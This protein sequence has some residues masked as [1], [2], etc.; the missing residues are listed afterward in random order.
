M[1][2]SEQMLS[3][4]LF[5]GSARY[6]SNRRTLTEE[7]KKILKEERITKRLF[8]PESSLL[9]DYEQLGTCHETSLQHFTRAMSEVDATLE[10][11]VA[12]REELRA[13]SFDKWYAH[14]RASGV[15]GWSNGSMRRTGAGKVL[16]PVVEDFSDALLDAIGM[17]GQYDI[18]PNLF[19][20]EALRISISRGTSPWEPGTSPCYYSVPGSF[21]FRTY[22]RRGWTHDGVSLFYGGTPPYCQQQQHA[23][24]DVCNR[25]RSFRD[26]F[27]EA[28][29][30]CK[31]R[32]GKG[33]KSTNVVIPITLD[34]ANEDGSWCVDDEKHAVLFVLRHDKAYV[35]DPLGMKNV[36][37]TLVKFFGEQIGSLATVQL[38]PRTWCEDSLNGVC[39]YRAIIPVLGLPSDVR[40]LEFIMIV[41]EQAR[42]SSLQ[43]ERVEKWHR[44]FDRR[45]VVR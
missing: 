29:E 39:G 38:P 11:A 18:M 28:K 35:I 31:A 26:V 32:E 44:L 17:S 41:L 4:I 21:D 1:W 2:A 30:Y 16:G 22:A 27:L 5:A 24:K 8:N 40:D 12:V 43:P 15:F 9:Y 37:P 13:L 33:R 25:G 19:A 45:R 10:K 36:A 20:L 3:R 42:L 14:L 7:E 6:R 34:C 23:R